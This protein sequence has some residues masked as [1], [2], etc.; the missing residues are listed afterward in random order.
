[1]YESAI[2]QPLFD[3][4]SYYIKEQR[5]EAEYKKMNLSFKPDR[6]MFYTTQDDGQLKKA[7]TL[8]EINK[9]LLDLDREEQKKL[10][11]KM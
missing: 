5:F 6:I 8:E 1:M 11:A 2:K 10:I 7:Y 4:G 9:L 3:W